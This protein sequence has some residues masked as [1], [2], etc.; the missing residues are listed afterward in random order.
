MEHGSG[1]VLMF[2]CV[3]VCVCVLKCSG[4]WGDELAVDGRD[5]EYLGGKLM[6]NGGFF[7]ECFER[8]GGSST[9]VY[10]GNEE[11]RDGGG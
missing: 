7:W 8:G 2:V 4:S 11:T 1:G 5:G 6:S 3:C 10:R 9:D